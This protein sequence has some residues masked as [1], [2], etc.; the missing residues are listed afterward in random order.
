MLQRDIMAKR[1][2]D[3]MARL[4][5]AEQ[6]LNKAQMRVTKQDRRDPSGQDQASKAQKAFDVLADASGQPPK[7]KHKQDTIFTLQ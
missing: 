2:A 6:L 7:K 1:A 3:P 4:L 5:T